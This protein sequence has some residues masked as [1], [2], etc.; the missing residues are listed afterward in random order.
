MS[1]VK[2]LPF[3]LFPLL[4]GVFLCSPGWSRAHHVDQAAPNSEIH[5]PP[6]PKCWRYRCEP[7]TLPKS[8]L[9]R[10]L[11]SHAQESCPCSCVQK[12]SPLSSPPQKILCVWRWKSSQDFNN[13]S[14]HPACHTLLTTQ[15][16]LELICI[17]MALQ[18]LIAHLIFCYL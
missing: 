16:P 9:Q 7:T 14:V 15:Y 10:A 4:R 5:L 3:F 17:P 13:V 12:G 6:A 18:Q 2:E 11:L 8:I 1:V